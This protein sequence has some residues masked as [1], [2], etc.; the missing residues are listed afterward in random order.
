MFQA[1]LAVAMTVAQ[2][3]QVLVAP[4]ESIHVEV[5]GEG[6]AVVL[7]PGLFGSAYGYRSVIRL[8]AAQGRRAIVIEP[9]GLGASSRPRKADYSLTAQ[10]DRIAAV[11]DSLDVSD[12]VVV[13]HAVGTGIALR[14]AVQRP[15]LVQS[16]ISLDGGPAEAAATPGFRRALEWAPLIRLFGGAGIIRR[17]VRSG[18]IKSSGDSSWVTDIVIAEYTSSATADVGATLRAFEGMARSRERLLVVPRLGGLRCPVLLIMGDAPHE[19]G[20]GAREVDLL[21][22]NLG[23][24]EL[25]IVPGAGSYLHEERPEVVAAA[26]ER[27]MGASLALRLGAHGAGV[28]R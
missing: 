22:R 11:L 19:G 25:Q 1:M 9:L 7:L 27:M 14:L 13:A 2:P 5:S 10:A 23:A 8:L 28:P 16:I 26:I 3:S 4:G 12:A 6:P 17:K 21:R 24:F 15:T 18:L 20:I